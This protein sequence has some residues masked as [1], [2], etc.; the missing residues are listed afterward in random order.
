MRKEMKYT[1]FKTKWGYFGILGN[2]RGPMKTCLPT[3]PEKVKSLLLKDLENAEYDKT[4]FG[5][6]AEQVTAY[7]EGSYVNFS[8]D[9]PVKLN[10]FSEFAMAVLN[11]CRDI[12]FGERMSYGQVAE[13]IGRPGAARAVGRVL[14]RNPLPL[15]IPCHRVICSNGGLGGFSAFGGV[16]M[17]KKML[18]LERTVKSRKKN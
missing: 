8:R 1:I 6:L 14:A 4:S 16:T 5:L 2:K 10:G 7:F 17:K 15:V 9:I 18:E 12:T 13:K 3:A 11:V